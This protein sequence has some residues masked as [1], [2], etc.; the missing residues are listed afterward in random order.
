MIKSERSRTLA[1]EPGQ[2][3]IVSYALGRLQVMP[4]S[5]LKDYIKVN[6]VLLMFNGKRTGEVIDLQTNK[7]PENYKGMLDLRL[8]RDQKELSTRADL[9]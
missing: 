8:F 1:A 2:P 5:L 7:L 4:D 3:P 6:D 9:R